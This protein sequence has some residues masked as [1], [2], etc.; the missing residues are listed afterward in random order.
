MSRAIKA[1]QAPQW[2]TWGVCFTHSMP[3]RPEADQLLCYYLRTHKSIH[4][5]LHIPS[6]QKEYEQYWVSPQTTPT[7]SLIKILLVMAIGTCF[8]P[9]PDFDAHRT[10]AIQWAYIA[11]SW[12]ASPR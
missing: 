8:Y 11:Q 6:F 4:R 7:V 9:G 5:I 10:Q 2:T 1:Y 12:L 3:I